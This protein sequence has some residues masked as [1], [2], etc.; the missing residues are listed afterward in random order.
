MFKPFNLTLDIAAN[1][2]NDMFEVSNNDLNTVRL[3]FKVKKG[4]DPLVITGKIVRLAIKKPDKTLVFQ[5]GGVTDGDNGL[6]EV[7]LDR[8]AHLVPGKHEAELMIYQDDETVLVTSQF[9]YKVN[10]AILNDKDLQ[11]TDQFPVIN[12]AIVAGEIL[13]DLDVAGLV[14]SAENAIGAADEANTQAVF[15]QTQGAYAKAEGDKAAQRTTELN[16]VDAVQFKDRQDAFDVQMGKQ[17]YYVSIKEFPRLSGETDDSPRIQRAIDSIATAGGGKLVLEAVKYILNTSINLDINVYLEGQGSAMW[18]VGTT[19]SYTGTG[20][21]IVYKSGATRSRLKGILIKAETNAPN[22]QNFTGID[23]QRGELLTIDDVTIQGALR[24]IDCSGTVGALYLVDINDISILNCKEEGILVSDTGSWKNGIRIGVKDISD[25]KIGIKVMKGNGNTIEGNASE[26][27]RN[28]ET[29]IMLTA[30]N[31]SI[32]GSLW[33]EN[34]VKGIHV[35]GGHHSIDGEIFCIGRIIVDGGTLISNAKQFYSTPA[36]KG[37]S[38]KNLKYW[39]SF[40]ETTGAYCYDRSAFKKLTI[41][42]TVNVQRT[43]EGFFRSAIGNSEM[44]LPNEV[45]WTKD[46]TMVVLGKGLN[47]KNLLYLRGP[48][49]VTSVFFRFTVDGIQIWSNTGFLVNISCATSNMLTE[50]MDWAVISYDATLKRFTAYTK[51]GLANAT[52]NYTMP[53]QLATPTMVRL[54][55]TSV[56]V[57][58]FAIFDRILDPLEITAITDL[59]V[60][61]S[62]DNRMVTAD[63]PDGSKWKVTIDDAGAITTTKL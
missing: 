16:G 56:Y 47:T 50:R 55:N 45:D 24:G 44:D 29:G 22:Y 42:D 8:Q 41:R 63:S 36:Y 40:D 33:I 34:S 59:R 10:K 15:A 19:L 17:K 61:P 18:K 7:L 13:K 51:S 25:N 37:I 31:W 12:Q 23:I 32:K 2:K 54:A 28:T 58:E 11:S 52:F 60:L 27:G 39:Y 48:D 5:T 62:F 46:W 38:K 1:S 26:I 43:D 6:C 30:G 49:N 3:N 53:T 35:T 21:A 14:N 4:L 9:Y 57:D 20:A